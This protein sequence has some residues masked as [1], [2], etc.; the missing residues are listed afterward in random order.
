MSIRRA[1][2]DTVYR[3]LQDLMAKDPYKIEVDGATRNETNAALARKIVAA[4]RELELLRDEAG[5]YP[6]GRSDS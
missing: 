3:V 1:A 6:R 4:L 5:E 2:V